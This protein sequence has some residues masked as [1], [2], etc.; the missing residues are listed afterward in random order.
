MVTVRNRRR[1]GGGA[2][3]RGLGLTEQRCLRRG[4]LNALW[5]GQRG[6]L[7]VR[8]SSHIIIYII[9]PYSE[10]VTSIFENYPKTCPC[11]LL[12]LVV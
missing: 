12:P 4:G 3:G 7:V 9:S 8:K 11:L 2:G 6:I 1:V 10:H 5:I